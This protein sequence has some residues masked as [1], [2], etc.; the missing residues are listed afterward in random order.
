MALLIQAAMAEEVT[1][2]FSTNIPQGWT[3]SA[4]PTGFEQVGSKRGCQFTQSTT[5]TLK[6]STG[7]SKIEI[8]CSFYT[9]VISEINSLLKHCFISFQTKKK[10]P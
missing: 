10:G 5:L 7:I 9:V 1:Y 6:G 2:D 3:S 4:K 8:L